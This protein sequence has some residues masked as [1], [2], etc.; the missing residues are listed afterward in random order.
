MSNIDIRKDPT[1]HSLTVTSEWPTPIEKVW[2]LWADPRMLERWWGP[3]TYPATFTQHALAP[4]G[5]VS[6]YMTSPEGDRYGG[7]WIIGEVD[8]PHRFTFLDGFA[9][10]DGN[11]NDEMPT[12]QAV[13]TLTDLGNGTTRMAMHSTFSSL[14]AMEQIVAMG[15]EE[16]LRGA[17]G[18]IGAILAE[19]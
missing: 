6:Y 19:A 13:V 4:G 17:M 12:T 1:T 14:E 18:Q 5:R 2:Q 3:P 16:G 8:A 7:Y 15:M 11:A 10:A 9:D